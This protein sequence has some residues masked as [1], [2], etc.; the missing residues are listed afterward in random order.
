MANYCNC[1]FWAY[2]LN[3]SKYFLNLYIFPEIKYKA[4][5]YGR[6]FFICICITEFVQ[7]RQMKFFSVILY[8]EGNIPVHKK[9]RALYGKK[10][11]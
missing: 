5:L 9:R 2:K 11:R 6:A 10:R 8:I 1:A 3:F 4:L 7:K